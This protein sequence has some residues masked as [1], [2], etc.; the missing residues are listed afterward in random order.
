[1][2]KNCCPTCGSPLVELEYR[3]K[4]PD[5]LALMKR[6]DF[7]CF[8]GCSRT[9]LHDKVIGDKGK[10]FIH[11]VFHP[12]VWRSEP[13]KRKRGEKDNFFKE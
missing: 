7:C 1:M 2:N 11:P 3:G 6:K 4:K 9:D 5:M 13:L 12:K 10:V 8:M